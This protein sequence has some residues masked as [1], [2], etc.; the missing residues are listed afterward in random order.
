M[1]VPLSNMI[2]RR[3]AWHHSHCAERQRQSNL[4]EMASLLSLLAMTGIRT[5]NRAIEEINHA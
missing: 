5:H 3:L 1:A 4:D 2:A